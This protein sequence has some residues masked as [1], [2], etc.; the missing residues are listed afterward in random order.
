[1]YT[2]SE[3]G[4]TGK[5]LRLIR[6][7]S[8]SYYYGGTVTIT[9]GSYTF[10]HEKDEVVYFSFGR[11]TTFD[12]TSIAD[13]FTEAELL[14]FSIQIERGSEVTGYESNQSIIFSNPIKLNGVGTA[15]DKIVRKDGVWKVERETIKRTP[16]SLTHVKDL[17]NT[18]VYQAAFAEEPLLLG[19]ATPAYCNRLRYKYSQSD[20]EHFYITNDNGA[21]LYVPIDYTPVA[22]DFEFE[23][24]LATPT[25]E[26]L[27][28]ADQIALNSIVSYD[29]ITYLYCDSEV[30]PTWDLEY[31]TS[32]VGGY[33][34][35]AWNTAMSEKILNE[36]RYNEIVAAMLVMN[37]E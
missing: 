2:I 23:C 18:K 15:Q 21:Y 19:G 20:E 26:D 32:R 35:E 16:V 33:T 10:Y 5:F 7:A 22:S 29:G 9:N 31:G 1:M 3:Q 37:Q 24:V 25:Y 17:T 8:R 13:V 27:P 30:Q 36:A 11:T 6:I 4:K 28:T 14:S 34:L 12:G